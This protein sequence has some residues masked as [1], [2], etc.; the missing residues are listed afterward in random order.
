VARGSKTTKALI[1][2]WMGIEERESF[3][4]DGH[5]AVAVNVD[6]SRGYIEARSGFHEYKNT[7]TLRANVHPVMRSGKLKYVL[8]VGVDANNNPRFEA[9]DVDTNTLSSAQELSTLGE[10]K[11][12]KEFNCSFANVIL[13]RDRNGDGTRESPSHVTIVS[14]KA[15]TY[16]F[17]P[18][19]DP[20]NLSL[21]D[22]SRDTIQLNSLNWG[23]WETTPRGGIIAEHKNM[24]F[25][26]GFKDEF[27]VHL[28]SPMDELQSWIPEALFE[29]QDRSRYK[30]GP[31]FFA[32]SDPFDPFGITAYHFMGVEENERITGL[33]S[34][35]EQLIVFTEKSIYSLTGVTDETMQLYKSVS[36]VGCVSHS[37]IVEVG[38]ILYFMARDGIYAFTGGGAEGAVQKISKPI[39]SLFSS[40][41]TPAHL[42]EEV[43]AFLINA[44]YP[45]KVVLETLDRSHV[46]HVQSRNQLWWSVD[47]QGSKG[48]SESWGLTLV[49]DY[50]HQAWSYYLM[51]GMTGG[52][53]MTCMYDGFTTTAGGKEEV[54]TSGSGTSSLYRYGESTDNDSDNAEKSIPMIYI[55]GRMFKNNDSVAQFRPVRLKMLSWGKGQSSDPA[56]WFIE[57]EESHADQ[58]T[59]DPQGLYTE[60]TKVQYS[61]GVIPL[62]PAEDMQFFYGVGKYQTTDGGSTALD[63][64]F[65]EVDWFTSKLENAS[66]RSRSFRFGVASGYGSTVRTPELII[67]GIIFEAD[68]GDSR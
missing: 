44:G 39:D 2:P 63:F 15:N 24:V 8:F 35:K 23:Y 28:T 62:H 13:V 51:S 55:T 46:L 40:R 33:K 20:E 6:F 26:A 32:W 27:T 66:L 4:T 64:K 65:Q 17:D 56:K 45:F 57:G 59:K 41:K 50:F 12:N 3:Q 47:L 58:Y 5:C 54:F 25:Y 31:Q 36:S 30:L 42:P 43:R 61:T 68:I 16:I 10:P 1:G 52:A 29:F 34:F 11:G 37:S 19:G 21:V 53:A 38:G 14:T 18:Y 67:Q 9:L 7:T 48:G 60:A 49:Y 22:L